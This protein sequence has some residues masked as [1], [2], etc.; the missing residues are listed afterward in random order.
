MA[1]VDINPNRL[2]KIKELG[3]DLAINSAEQDPVEVMQEW[4][5][6]QGMDFSVDAVGHAN[7][8][9]NTVLATAPGGT[10]AWIGLAEDLAEIESRN[11]V[12]RELEIKGSYAFTRQDFAEA[13]SL[14]Q[15]KA[16]PV[17]SFVWK[18]P[19]EEGQR[20][21]EELNSGCPSI[22]KVVFRI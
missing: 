7:C 4:T 20:I 11:V 22:M 15:N 1:V 18:K 9:R 17:G 19:L 8:R 10:V 16:L 12:T 3:A 5:S 14:L 2:A 6:G 13:L 21:F